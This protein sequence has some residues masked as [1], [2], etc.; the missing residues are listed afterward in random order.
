VN[1]RVGTYVNFRV[2]TFNP[3]SELETTDSAD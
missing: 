2:G 3:N 1:F